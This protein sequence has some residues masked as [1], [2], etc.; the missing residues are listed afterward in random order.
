[1]DTKGEFIR[2][3]KNIKYAVATGIAALTVFLLPTI[4]QTQTKDCAIIPIS[5]GYIDASELTQE[6]FAHLPLDQQTTVLRC[7]REAGNSGNP[8][9]KDGKTVNA[10][11][12]PTA[13]MVKLEPKY[14]VYL[15]LINKNSKPKATVAISGA[16]TPIATSTA[17]P[18][19]TLEVTAEL[20][21][22]TTPTMESTVTPRPTPTPKFN[23]DGKTS[24]GGGR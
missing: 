13:T 4:A 7:L 19:P 18:S 1:M 9:F 20:Q 11:P 5:G 2:G 22:T 16:S 17:T 21:P 8:D 6:Q 15:S 14:S 3:L 10:T 24:L 23:D 12:G